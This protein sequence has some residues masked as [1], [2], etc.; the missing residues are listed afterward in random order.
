MKMT[1]DIFDSIINTSQDCVFWKDK[2]RRFIG[3]NQAF[4]D[5][6]GFESADVLIGK[7]DEDMGWHTDPEPYKQDELAVLAGKSTYKVQG[8]CIIRGEERDIIASKRPLSIG[9]EIVGLVGSFVDITDVVRRR[10]KNDGSQVL[11]TIEDLRKYKF[12]DKI[13][14]EISLAEILDPL[15][16]LLTRA[17]VIRF[18]QSLIAENTPFTFTII[19]LDNFKFINDTYGHTA[20]DK[21]LTSIT[22][23]LVEFTDGYGLAG[24]FGGDEILFIDLKHITKED[25][26]QFFE[27]LYG[28]SNVLRKEVYFGNG[29][30]FVTGTAGCA[31]F[32]EDSK[33]FN[34]LFSLIDKMLYLGKN[35]GRNCFTIYNEA[36]HKDIEIRKIANNGIFTSMHK[37]KQDIENEKG[38]EKKLLK[39]LPQLNDVLQIH[40]LFYVTDD[41]KM[42]AVL[43]KSF[44]A[45]ASD[46]P[47]VMEEDL[48]SE[49]TLD[50]IKKRSPIFYK[51]LTSNG[52]ETVLISRIR[53]GKTT[54]GYLVCAVKRSLRI[55]QENECAILFYLSELLAEEA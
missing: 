3:V 20:G 15:T 43:D 54:K 27:D 11:Y 31:S 33:D 52:F 30:A 39:A 38:F 23:G 47:D 2:D 44:C 17:Y 26:V 24:R 46:L 51:S 18:V 49:S 42:R 13:I 14:D 40:D 37:L 28:S 55:W 21:V 22:K 53:K 34:D 8:K 32:P 48:F 16:G 45:D 10:N 7:N 6:Y 25:K 35:K 12:F 19:D 29:A 4:L 5:Y 9:N 1:G 50:L 36:K 41:G